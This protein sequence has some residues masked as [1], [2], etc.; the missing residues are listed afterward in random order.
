MWQWSKLA[1]FL[2]GCNILIAESPRP[3]PTVASRRR[4][5]AV[6]DHLSRYVTITGTKEVNMQLASQITALQVPAVSI[7][8]IFHGHIDW[9]KAYGSSAIGGRPEIPAGSNPARLYAESPTQFFVLDGPQE[10]SFH[11]DAQHKADSVEFMTPMS[12]SHLPRS[13]ARGKK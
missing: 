11:V 5:E 3:R 1:L 7:A 6:E 8:A 4:M 9:T 2:M 10:L 13:E 12:H